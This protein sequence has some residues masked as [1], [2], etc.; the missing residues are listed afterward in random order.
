[1]RIDVNQLDSEI[2]SELKGLAVVVAGGEADTTGE[3]ESEA[4]N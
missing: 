4:I 3:V 1:M 2:E